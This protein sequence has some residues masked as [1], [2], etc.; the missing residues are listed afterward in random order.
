LSAPALA[1]DVAALASFEVADR[2]ADALLD[3]ASAS[4]TSLLAA[5]AAPNP[6]SRR[7]DLLTAAAAR[8]RSSGARS[9]EIDAL[10]ALAGSAAKR[11][12]E[13]LCRLERLSRDAGTTAHPQVLAWLDD[14][15]RADRAV[16]PLALRRRAEKR[17]RD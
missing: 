6:P 2:V 1:A 16:L 8:A 3:D 12:S 5:A 4:A 7:E 17:A 14:A 13:L 15:A 11:T 9:E 10:F